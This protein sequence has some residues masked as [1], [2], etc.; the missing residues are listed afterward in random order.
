MACGDLHK[1]DKKH[2]HAA[3]TDPPS[4]RNSFRLQ[5]DKAYLLI[6]LSVEKSLQTHL[7]H[8]FY[9][10]IMSESACCNI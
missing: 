6:A 4:V 10:A 8:T 5:S 1:K 3:S 7:N 9:A 2:L